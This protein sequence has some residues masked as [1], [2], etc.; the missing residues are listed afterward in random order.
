[1][2]KRRIYKIAEFGLQITGATSFAIGFVPCFFGKCDEK[3]VLISTGIGIASFVGSHFPHTAL[4]RLEERDEILE[5]KKNSE[6]YKKSLEND[7]EKF[8]RFGMYLINRTLSWPD[9]E[10]KP[11]YEDYDIDMEIFEYKK[12][13]LMTNDKEQI[14]YLY[15][16]IDRLN[17]IVKTDAYLSFKEKFYKQKNQKVLDFKPVKEENKVLKLT[18]DKKKTSNDDKE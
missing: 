4:Y 14:D 8:E 1:M 6:T 5:S 3:T 7:I 15:D 17:S 11:V 16:H 12:Q 9:D 2:G 10:S 13:L 18:N